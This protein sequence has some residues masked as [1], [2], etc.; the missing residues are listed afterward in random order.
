MSKFKE[1]KAKGKSLCRRSLVY[2]KGIND[3]DYIVQLSEKGK[4][5]SCP[6]YTRWKQMLHRCYYG[7]YTEEH[8]TYKDCYVC[9]E[10]LTFSSFKAWM[11]KQEWE[12]KE[13]DKDILSCGNKVY[14]PSTC[15][16]ISSELNK[17]F[18]I[19]ERGRSLPTGVSIGS[20]G[21]RFRSRCNRNGKIINLGYFNSVEEAESAYLSYKSHVVYVEALKNKE[22]IKSSLIKRSEQIKSKAQQLIENRL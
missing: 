8:G 18:A 12:G 5:I 1:I 11:M 14:S 10:W 22:P 13:L 3:A 6:F 21:K 19:P 2:G 15:V 7:K 9:D 17:L 16:F 20:C 4:R